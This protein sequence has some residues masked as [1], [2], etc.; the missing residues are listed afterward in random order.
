[1][2]LNCPPMVQIFMD[3]GGLSIFGRGIF[4]P[5]V[6][7][8]YRRTSGP[9]KM[10]ENFQLFS[11]AAQRDDCYAAKSADSNLL[12]TN[13]AQKMCIDIGI[14]FRI[15]YYH[16][17]NPCPFVNR[18][19]YLIKTMP[20]QEYHSIQA[21]LPIESNTKGW[22]QTGEMSSVRWMDS[23]G[24]KP[25]DRIWPLAL[26]ISLV[27]RTT[28]VFLR[29]AGAATW[30]PSPAKDCWRS[31]GSWITWELVLW[32]WYVVPDQIACS[33]TEILALVRQAKR[34]FQLSHVNFIKDTQNFL[35]RNTIRMRE[36]LYQL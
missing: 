31:S 24:N 22:F 30:I 29:S 33:D 4:E 19:G 8:I 35:L 2:S 15:C 20:V 1:M 13:W 3:P 36:I 14:Q 25:S 23:S 28:P 34:P 32:S 5:F 16:Y 12:L 11:D 26:A 7:H 17:S 9:D 10:A 18:I 27:K 6:L 21:R